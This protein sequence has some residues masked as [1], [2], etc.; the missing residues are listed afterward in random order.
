MSNADD[1]D[2]MGDTVLKAPKPGDKDWA[3]VLPKDWADVIEQDIDRQQ[4]Q[5]SQAPFS[6]AYMAG[7]PH[8]RRKLIMSTRECM[9]A[10]AEEHLHGTLA[11]AMSDAGVQPITGDSNEQVAARAN[12][13]APLMQAHA[14]Q[15]D[16]SLRRR[17]RGDPDFDATK[18]PVSDKMFNKN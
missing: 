2:D 11:Q 5:P 1:D 15:V 13:D 9:G 3:K 7:I 14:N 17:V 6:D 8:K 12:R 4:H 16:A 18:F 10:T